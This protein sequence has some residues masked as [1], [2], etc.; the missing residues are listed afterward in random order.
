MTY[1][2]VLNC[3]LLE[4]KKKEKRYKIIKYLLERD[5]SKI[6]HFNDNNYTPLSL[7]CKKNPG[8]KIIKL[9]VEY[10]AQVDLE[11]FLIQENEKNSSFKNVT[12]NDNDDDNDDDDETEKGKRKQKKKK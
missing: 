10:G 1:K 7:A 2:H 5:N 6:N 11:K 8:L 9:L 3:N 12:E 4:E